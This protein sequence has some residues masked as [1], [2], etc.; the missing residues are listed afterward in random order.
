MK[1][2]LTLAFICFSTISFAQGFRVVSE[3]YPPFEYLD[4]GKEAGLDIEI[5]DAAKA[6]AGI[7]LKIEFLPWNRA[8]DLVQKGSADAIFSLLRNGEREA[9]LHFPAVPLYISR[10]V[11]FAAKDFPGDIAS[12]DELKGKTVGVVLGNSYGATFDKN[13]S[14]ARDG[15]SDQETMVKKFITG[16]TRLMIT[17]EEVGHYLLKKLGGKDYR[18]LSLEVSK[19]QYF[20]GVSKNSP[21][22]KEFFDKLSGALSELDKAGELNKI[23]AKYTK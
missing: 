5:L 6:K 22:G 19:D 4:G 7:D 8:L 21:R 15:A 18:V 17:S 11:L 16:R 13:T 9:F 1:S 20:I 23:R 14:F 10:T 2:I 12:F 3:E